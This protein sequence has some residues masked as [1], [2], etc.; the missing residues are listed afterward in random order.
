MSTIR[1]DGQKRCDQC[2][3]HRPAYGALICAAGTVARPAQFAREAGACGPDGFLWRPIPDD[4]PYR[5]A[6][7][8][9]GEQ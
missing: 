4:H 8:L 5:R 6:S 9:K 2:S 3:N 1:Y 7:D